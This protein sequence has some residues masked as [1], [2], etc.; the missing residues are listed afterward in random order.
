ML[1]DTIDAVIG[2]DT[3]RDTHQV[4]I[5]L[6]ASTPIATRAIPNTST[7][8]AQLLAWIGEHSPGPRV[9]AS[10]EG[11]RSYGAGLARTLSNA[12]LLVIEC[13]QPSRTTR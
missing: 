7:G 6:P 12:G 11:T 8:F 5:A 2:V 10:V 13:E 4:E 1:A 9:V 3:H